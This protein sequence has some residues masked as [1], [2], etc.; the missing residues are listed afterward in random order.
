MPQRIVITRI[1]GPEAL[2]IESFD[3]VSPG[4]GEVA[5]DV[6]AVGLNFAD[7][8]CRHGMYKAA[9]PLPFSPGFE[10]AG[11][12]AETG[13]GVSGFKP[14]DRVFAV[15]RFGGYTTRLH[16]GEE[17]VRPLPEEWSF[18]DGAAFPVAYLTAY[19]GLVNL[20]QTA[21]GETVVVQSAAGGVGTAGCAL[22]RSLGGSV[23]GTVGSEGKK[24][25]ALDAGAQDVIVDPDYRVWDAVD[26]LTGGEGVDVVFES[27]GGSQVRRGFEA[28][29]PGGRLLI[30]G[31]SQMIPQGSRRNW[32]VLAWRYLRTPRFNPFRMTESNRSVAGYN[33][34]HLWGR[35]DLFQRA[36]TDL[37]DRA[38]RGEVRPFLGKTFPFHRAGDAQT[39]LQT[40]RSTGKVVLV[41]DE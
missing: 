14:G 32:P 2:A 29:K 37:L 4:P 30:Y 16:I 41:T 23:I 11:T 15:T 22:V 28:L 34:V 13:E 5:V 39:F 7:I 31:Y 24:Q 18:A 10:V 20:G 40:R 12:I 1:G 35:V 3:A 25:V 9:P 38:S 36:I 26:R 21:P 19:Y 6:K 33:I 8:F 27:V 17:W